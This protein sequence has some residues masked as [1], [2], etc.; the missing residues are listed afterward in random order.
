MAATDAVN[1][2]ESARPG[3]EHT[4]V[5]A[6]TFRWWT[7]VQLCF[8][9][10]TADQSHGFRVVHAHPPEAVSDGGCLWN[11]AE[12]VAARVCARAGAH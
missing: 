11:A 8:R 12:Q 7:G 9:L 1:I 3:R 6:S 4:P 2:R 5:T 10:A